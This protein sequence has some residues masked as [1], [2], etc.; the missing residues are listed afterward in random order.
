[1]VYG[2]YGSCCEDCTRRQT[3]RE[4]ARLYNVPIETL[5]RR[6]TGAVSM[7]CRPGPPT[8]LI[9][10]EED[11]LVQYLIQMADMGYGLSREACMHMVGNFVSACKR[12]NPFKNEKA[13]RWWFEGF[14]ARHP[15]LTIRKPQ[16]LSYCRALCSNKDIISD[17]FGK[18]GAI[19]GKLNLIAKP[20]QIYNSDEIGVTI[21]H[22]PTKV[23]AELG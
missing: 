23:L 9:K 7:D 17:F 10:D 15:I 4:T 8:V 3:L 14:K 6:V 19:Y 1:M 11:K 18:L 21:V 22:K 12:S 16:P 13:G 20:M 5:R 2:K